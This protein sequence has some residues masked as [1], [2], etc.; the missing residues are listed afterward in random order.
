VPV[1]GRYLSFQEREEI[2]I[3]HGGTAFRVEG[4]VAMA[5]W[6]AGIRSDE[7]KRL[8]YVFALEDTPR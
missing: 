1:S 4:L 6:G 7:A 2:A 5:G 3:L 8:R